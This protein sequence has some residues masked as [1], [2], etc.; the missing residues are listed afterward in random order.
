MS[1]T[2]P[3]TTAPTP[4][5][6]PPRPSAEAE[7]AEGGRGHRDRLLVGGLS[8]I[9]LV[10]RLVVER[11]LWLD[12]A[13]SA[14]QAHLPFA[15]M[16]TDLRFG[17]VHPPGHHSVLWAVVRLLGDGELALRAPSIAAGVAVIPLLYLTG[18]L[19]YD[20]RAGLAAAAFGTVAPLMVWYSHEARA[21]ALFMFL[22]LAAVYAQLVVLKRPRTWGWLLYVAATVALLWTHYF[23]SIQVAIQLLAFVLVAWS[24]W[25]SGRPV[26]RE[27]LLPLTAAVVVIGAAMVPLAPFAFDQYQ[28]NT[29]SGSSGSAELPTQAGGD[30]AGLDD[31]PSVYALGANLVWAIWGFHSDDVM[32]RIVGLWPLSMLLGLALLGRGRSMATNLLVATV[33]SQVAVLFAVGFHVRIAFEVRQFGGAVPLLLLLIARFVTTVP[34]RRVYA[35]VASLGV[36]ATLVVGLVDQQLNQQNPRIHDVRGAIEEIGDRADDGDVV[37]YAPPFLAD[38]VGYYAR[39]LQDVRGPGES[40]AVEPGTRVYLLGGFLDEPRYAAV[41]GDTLARLEEDHEVVDEFE[42]P[43]IRVWVLERS[44]DDPRAQGPPTDGLR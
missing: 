11:G 30:A 25:R 35:A 7:S 29:G 22:A 40:I 43:Q 18:R 36:V 9:A 15:E 10:V 6:P 38:V 20:R 39:D 26:L 13:I 28:A 16:L 4:T 8:L 41:V 2:S 34:Q 27:L 44:M 24:R 14:R 42:H 17:D 19:A 31:D 5:Q 12:E 32:T 3:P 37:V 23:A 33:V 21:Y 1:V